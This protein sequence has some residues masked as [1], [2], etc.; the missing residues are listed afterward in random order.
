MTRIGKPTKIV[1]ISKAT[2]DEPQV[3]IKDGINT[4]ENRK[5]RTGIR[6]G[7]PFL[8]IFSSSS[9]HSDDVMMKDITGDMT[10]AEKST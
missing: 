1:A 8:L 9:S 4:T 10:P 2:C 3:I 5:Q 7:C 6:Q